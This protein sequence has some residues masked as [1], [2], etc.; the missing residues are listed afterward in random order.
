MA[1]P[2]KRRQCCCCGG[3]W[4]PPSCPAP[5]T[6]FVVSARHISRNNTEVSRSQSLQQKKAQRGGS[7]ATAAVRKD[8]RSYRGH[9]R[10]CGSCGAVFYETSSYRFALGPRP[11]F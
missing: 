2:V 11:F 8:H 4:M 6:F 9:S 1:S 7:F 10:P 3:F 5:S